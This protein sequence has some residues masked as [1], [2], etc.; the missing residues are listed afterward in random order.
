VLSVTDDIPRVRQ[1]VPHM[2][3][4]LLRLRD[5]ATFEEVR[6]QYAATVEAL[7]A[8]G[9]GR[10][11]NSRLGDRYAGWSAARDVLEEGMRLGW[12]ERRPL[13]SSKVRVENYANQPFHLTDAGRDAADLA[14]RDLS[15]FVDSLTRQTVDRHP[16][17]K[18]LLLSLA[19]S[20]LVCP[21]TSEGEV[22]RRADEGWTTDDWATWGATQ[23]NTNVGS[24]ARPSTA[25]DGS[26]TGLLV[27]LLGDR[28]LSTGGFPPADPE[29]VK[30]EIV[31]VFRK[32]FGKVPPKR[33]S[34][35]EALNDAFA[36]ASLQ[37]RR[38]P[39]G[40]TNLRS[41][42]AWGSQLRILDESRYVL[43]SSPGNIVW[44]AADIAPEGSGD[45]SLTRRGIKSYGHQVA[46]ALVDA[47]YSRAREMRGDR[48]SQLD[49]P[50]VPIFQVRA[51]AAFKTG[52]TR[53]LCDLVLEQMVDGKRPELGV[54]VRLH[55]GRDVPPPS[56]PVYRRGGRRR[57]EMTISKHREEQP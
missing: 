52:V 11:T 45:I 56:E 28:A 17:F 10:K 25:L 55:L 18:F 31:S 50:Y 15:A 4:Q 32:R 26:L 53:S 49:A 42:K 37:A 19:V 39:M 47:Y 23:M 8:R 36:A 51:E 12:I 24:E 27:P 46:R 13:P 16:Y 33:K 14:A 2:R 22:A 35:T 1:L 20:P 40:A 9:A 38:L 6:A 30:T 7:A 21:E 43:G 29:V 54:E 44:L 48:S 57:F 5:G 34:R 3:D 41:L